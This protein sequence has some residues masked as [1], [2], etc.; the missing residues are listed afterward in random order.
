MLRENAMADRD[1]VHSEHT[2]YEAYDPEH[3]LDSILDRLGLDSDVALAEAL[4][5]SP[6]VVDD[7]RCMRRPVDPAMLIW[8]HELTGIDVGG[9]RNIL[10][11]RRGDLRP[12]HDESGRAKGA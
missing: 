10:G 11:D 7:I 4:Q 2:D 6:S 9:L 3:L 5:V 12:S 8:I 1:D